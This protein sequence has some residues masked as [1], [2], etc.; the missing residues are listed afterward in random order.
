M[1]NR[2]YLKSNESLQDRA[3]HRW[4]LVL[5]LVLSVMATPG[6]AGAQTAPNAPAALPKDIVLVLD[7]SGSMRKNDPRF[8]TKEA[9]V[10]F[11]K[12][13]PDEARGSVVIFD[14]HILAIPL[15]SRDSV[16][17]AQ[18]NYRGLLTNI[19]AA[20]ARA[21]QELK[22]NG[23]PGA[24]RSVVLLTDGVVDTGT[25]AQDREV[26]HWLRAQLVSAATSTGVKIFTVALG[27]GSDNELLQ[28]LA[29]RTGGRY[30][31]ARQA[32]D[33]PGIFAQ[34]SDAFF[35]PAVLQA[36]LERVPQ[37]AQASPPTPAVDPAPSNLPQAVSPT[38][39][40]EKASTPPS[41]APTPE[42][43]PRRADTGAP[44]PLV[45]PSQ[46]PSVVPV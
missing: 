9:V 25:K 41:N 45:V 35:A 14:K 7:N 20:V 29:Q 40:R 32:Q 6:R 38:A 22:L 3:S 17:L 44:A 42:P 15:K 28:E 13:W 1:E 31:W 30:F 21:I 12:G 2:P 39:G 10:Q 26:T 16:N 37:L 34:V 24:A 33:L 46:P 4:A 23:R 43:E 5:G 27:T 8:L 36:P 18:F 19:P 11:I